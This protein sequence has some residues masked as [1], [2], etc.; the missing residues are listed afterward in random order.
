MAETL[1]KTKF[2]IP[3]KR[4]DLVSRQRLIEKLNEGLHR[5]LTL[6]STPA[7]FG[8]TT[9]VTEW[10]NGRDIN[11]YLTAW[12]SL[13]EG[14]NDPMR[15]L[16][17]FIAAMIETNGLDNDF[18]K[19]ML[20]MLQSTQPP[21]TDAIISLIINE[22][23]TI[24]GKILIAL[25]DYH[26]ISVQQVHDAITY[27]LEHLPPQVHLVIISRENPPLQLAHLRALDQITELRAIDL[28]FTDSEASE[29]LNSIMQLKLTS[30]D[31]ETLTARTE[32]WVTGL[33]LAG[34][35]LRGR[36]DPTQFIKSFSGS[37]RFVL[38]YLIEEVLDQQTENFR[39]FLL[40]TAI[41][42]RLTG[43][44]CDALT[45]QDN[46]Q[47]TLELLEHANLFIVPL[48]EE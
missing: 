10:L 33:Q 48:D 42:E 35:S 4:P 46:G 43:P 45:N 11:Q 28:R 8:K 25:D 17:Y 15:F 7:G 39:A 29:F 24:S 34:I 30:Q 6:I 41:L 44:L 36:V 32:G 26:L 1:L 9:L 21:S 47:A 22:I 2:Y 12:V 38:D 40:K 27:F 20:S 16:S 5:K 19:S 3:S 31:I 14:D 18:G 13:D 37:H 23:T